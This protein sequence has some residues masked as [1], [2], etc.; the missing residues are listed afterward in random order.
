MAVLCVALLCGLLWRIAPAAASAW[1]NEQG[2]LALNSALVDTAI[3][4][5]TRQERLVQAGQLFQAALSWSP[6]NAAAY[7]N[8]AAIYAVWEQPAATAEALG[9][10][11]ALGLDDPSAHLLLGNAYF[12]LD[13][14]DEAA[15]EWREAKAGPYLWAEVRRLMAAGD[16]PRAERTLNLAMRVAGDSPESFRV[17]AELRLA[18]G[19]RQEARSAYDAA[20][21]LEADPVQRLVTQAQSYLVQR[22]VAS[23]L[24]VYRK[25]AAMEPRSTGYRLKLAELYLQDQQVGLAEQEYR[26]ILLLDPGNDFAASQ[27]RRLAQPGR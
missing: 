4:A 18:Q 20:I 24:E 17:L 15:A 12:A 7:R 9:R 2:R 14:E 6:D 21:S 1:C 3:S 26:E 27:L 16:L 8:L 13:R 19:R 10:A 25:L 23:A 11:T 22:D 5:D